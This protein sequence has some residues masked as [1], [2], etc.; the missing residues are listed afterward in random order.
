MIVGLNQAGQ[1]GFSR[2]WRADGVG[3]EKIS[4]FSRI[5]SKVGRSSAYGRT[6]GMMK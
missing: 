4:P 6:G 5:R 2:G 1:T 3:G